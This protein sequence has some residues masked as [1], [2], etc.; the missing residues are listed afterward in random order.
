MEKAIEYNPFLHAQLLP[1][2]ASLHMACITT[3]HTLATFLPPLSH[4]KVLHFW[5]GYAADVAEGLRD[6]IMILLPAQSELSEAEAEVVAVVVL[7]KPMAETGPFR[8]EVLKLFVSPEHRKKGLAKR[9][10]VKLE[11]VARRE[12]RTLLMLDTETGSP[13][14]SVYPRLGYTKIGEIPGFGISPQDGSLRTETFFYK[15]LRQ[16]EPLTLK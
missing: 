12:E 14:E 5:Q 3:D 9:L 16:S 7:H 15:D 4:A 6:I 11:E 1:S 2:I 10:M 13:A 8:A